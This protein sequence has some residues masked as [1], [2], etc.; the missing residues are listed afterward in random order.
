MSEFLGFFS[1]RQAQMLDNPED[2]LGSEHIVL[3]K[4]GWRTSCPCEGVV[5]AS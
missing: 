3:K 4:L 5:D 2:M 1:T